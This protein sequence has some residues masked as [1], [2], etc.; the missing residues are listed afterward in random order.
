MVKTSGTKGPKGTHEVDESSRFKLAPAE[1]V[2]VLRV[3]GT[4]QHIAVP[5]TATFTLGRVAMPDDAAEPRA[6]IALRSPSKAVS[7]MHAVFEWRRDKLW[8]RDGGSTNGTFANR[9]L[10][11]EWFCVSPGMRLDF[12]DVSVSALDANLA[13]L[14]EPLAWCL[15]L[16]AHGAVDRALNLVNT[17][18][19]LLLIGPRHHDQEWL[20]RKIHEGSGRRA[21]P[22][23]AFTAKLERDATTRLEK[24]RFGTA[25]VD[26]VAVGKVTN[27]FANALFAGEPPHLLVRPI[28]AAKD[29]LQSH[30]AFMRLGDAHALEL[31]PLTKRRDEIVKLFDLLMRKH[32]SGSRLKDLEPSIIE[33]LIQHDWLG[34]DEI[35]E[36]ELRLR[37]II[38]MPNRTRAAKM[39][40]SS[41]QALNKYLHRLLGI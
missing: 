21:Y 32:G 3:R 10:Q 11:E 37:A 38:E 7:L 14:A 1:P 2:S 26:L 31:P 20:A 39:V 29:Q 4:G 13:E 25:F 40:G 23:A 33:R 8:C 5:T 6:T 24:A 12:G 22:F 9:Q 15:G 41:R 36:A 35:R 16:D 30:R 27:A 28:V 34:M 19:P 18:G 17:G